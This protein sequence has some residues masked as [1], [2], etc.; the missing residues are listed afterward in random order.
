MAAEARHLRPS[1]ARVGPGLPR[2]RQLARV[3]RQAML[4]RSVVD[5][6]DRVAWLPMTIGATLRMI[7]AALIYW[8]LC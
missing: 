5:S 3:R 4:G 1:T 8:A 2:W 7:S 6:A